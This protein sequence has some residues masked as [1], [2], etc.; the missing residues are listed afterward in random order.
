[1]CNIKYFIFVKS[2][3]C[4][5]VTSER[6]RE[7]EVERLPLQCDRWSTLIT[8]VICLTLRPIYIQD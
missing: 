6:E 5:Y 4:L 8:E 1:M 3:Y 2:L 7:R